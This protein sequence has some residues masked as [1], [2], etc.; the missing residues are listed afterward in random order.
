MS[1]FLILSAK[2]GTGHV[3]AAQALEKSF[4]S[5]APDA[6]VIH[7][8]A[9]RFTNAAFRSLYANLYLDLVNVAPELFGWFYDVADRPWKNQEQRLAFERL[10]TRPLKAFLKDCAPD[11]VICTHF[12]PAEII[13]W[14]LCRGETSVQSAVVAT[15]IDISAMWLC[16]HYSRYFVA[17]EES[18]RHLEKLGFDLERITVSGIPIDPEFAIVK[19]KVAMRRKHGLEPELPVVLVSAGGHGVGRMNDTV[20]RLLEMTIESQVVCLCG[21]NTELLENLRQRQNDLL[22]AGSLV[23]LL[24]VGYTQEMDELLAAADLIV[25]KAGG[26]TTAEAAARGVPFV[27]VDP[28]PGQEERNADHLLEEGAAMRCNNLPVLAYKVQY[29]LEN[30]KLLARLRENAFSIAAPRAAEVIV[31]SALKMAQSPLPFGTSPWTHDCSQSWLV[32]VIN[33]DGRK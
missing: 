22:E 6:E 15:D 2:I 29:I 31:R 1:R 26:L 20:E 32:P 19:D 24:P 28:I 8:D 27:F 25:G 9:L 4:G 16:H 5:I 30:E 23:R 11:V 7:E 17:R 12:L 10:N 3:R 14:L 13:S 21:K 33:A 18:R